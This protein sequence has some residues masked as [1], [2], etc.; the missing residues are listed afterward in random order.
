MPTAAL[1]CLVSHDANLLDTLCHHCRFFDPPEVVMRPGNYSSGRH[2]ALREI[3]CAVLFF[4]LGRPN[5]QNAQDQFG[6]G[7]H[8]L[9]ISISFSNA[10]LPVFL[11]CQRAPMRFHCQ[12]YH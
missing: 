4:L 7:R 12:A 2:E 1:A 3:A 9:S 6:R 8:D 5:P 10:C 11:R